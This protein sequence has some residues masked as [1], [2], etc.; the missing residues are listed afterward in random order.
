MKKSYVKPATV[1]FDMG[2]SAFPA[3]GLALVGGVRSWKSSSSCYESEPCNK[4]EK[5]R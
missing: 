3:V 5:I 1:C 4:T 2:K